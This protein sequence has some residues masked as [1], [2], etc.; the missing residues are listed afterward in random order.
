M[1]ENL[2]SYIKNWNRIQKQTKAIMAAAPNDKYEWKPCESAMSLGKLMNHLWM[3]EWGLIEAALTGAFP[4]EWPAEINDTAAM[5]E[6]FDKSH[7]ESVA[8]VSALTAEQLGEE[9]APFGP[10]KAMSR[11]AFLNLTNEHEIH[12][13]GQLYTYLRIAGCEVPPL[14]A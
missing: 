3:A 13:R 2:D 12:H 7:A 8:K 14:Y 1:A 5:V 10:D 9:I 11:M 4:K 6:A